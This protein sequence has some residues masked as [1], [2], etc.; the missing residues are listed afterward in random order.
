MEYPE[1]RYEYV[2]CDLCGSNKHSIFIR[3]AKD[4][5][6]NI[7]G[8][9]NIVKCDNCGLIFTNPRPYGEELKK[10]YPDSAGYF[11][12]NMTLNSIHNNSSIKE[13]LKKIVYREYYDYFLEE[14]KNVIQKVVIYSLYLF[15]KKNTLIQGLP[16]FKKD[17]RLLD[18]GCSTGHY[19]WR[20]QQLGW[21][22]K[23]IEA[24]QKAASWGK[25]NLGV[26]IECATFD[27]FQPDE[28]FDVIEMRMVLEHL[29]SPA[30]ALE[31]VSSMLNKHGELII[32][33]PDISGFEASVY[34]TYHYGL[35]P[36]CHFYHFTPKTIR[37]Y[38]EKYGFKVNHIVHHKLDKDLVVS[39]GYLG[40]HGKLKWLAPILH[41][42]F[43]RKIGVKLFVN[44][45][46][47]AG[48]TSRMT[49]KATLMDS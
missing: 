39:A 43:I 46:S 16:V 24:N 36:P 8:E 1:D 30:K 27:K 23:G 17:G 2:N 47:L 3:G 33:I 15:L 49:V 22:V 40:E 38:L 48:K 35:H 6:N 19:V 44:L 4:L 42:K 7:P 26:D 5:Y 32:I 9:F 10:Y 45:L 20:M 28:K 31:K 11:N 25:S 14:E 34:K 37:N 12:A 21:K 18:I 13:F 29:P 41:N